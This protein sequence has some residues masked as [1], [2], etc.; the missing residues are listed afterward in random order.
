MGYP[1]VLPIMSTASPLGQPPSPVSTI[2]RRSVPS[3]FA[4]S[5]REC[6]PQSVQYMWLREGSR[7][8]SEVKVTSEVGQGS[9]QFNIHEENRWSI[10]KEPPSSALHL[11]LTFTHGP[12]AREPPHHHPWTLDPPLPPPLD[13]L[14]LYPPL[15]SGRVEHERPGLVQVPVQQHLVET[16]AHGGDGDLLPARVRV[17]DETGHVVQRQPVRDRVC[18]EKARDLSE[19]QGRFAGSR[20]KRK[21]ITL[22]VCVCVCV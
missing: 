19:T 11:P 5:M 4:F 18:S 2:L 14:P 1:Q 21:V 9:V 6:S 3:M 22:C 15:P 16:S 12:S 17:E 13:P 7:S 20:Q 8:G 10:W